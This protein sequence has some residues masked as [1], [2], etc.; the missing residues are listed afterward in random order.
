M[1]Q[2]R[3]RNFC[4]IAHIDHGKSTLTDRLLEVTGTVAHR[5]MV[6]QVMDQMDLEREKGITI[7][8]KAVRMLYRAQDGIEYEM[9]LIDTPG[10]VDF[11]YEVSRA[12][13]ACEGAVLVVDATQG[14]EAQTLAN[15]YLSMPAFD[16]SA[17]QLNEAL[18]LDAGNSEL[19]STLGRCL[20]RQNKW[21][22]ALKAFQ[23][24][25]DTDPHDPE[26]LYNIGDAFLGLSQPEKAVGPLLQ[27]V[28]LRH[29]YSLAHY[30]LSLAFLELRKYPEAETSAR[31][32]LRDDPDMAFQLSNLGMGA[33]G[34]LGIALMNQGQMKEAE[35][36]FRHN[37]G[38]VAST[39]FNLGLTLFRT[40]RFTEALENFRRALELEPENPEFHNLIGQT[41]DE[42][43]QPVEAEQSLRRA[44]EIDGNYALGYYDMGVI[45][46]KREG[47]NQEALVAFEQ[48]LK[49][50]PDIVDAHYA[51]ACL[52]ALSQKEELAL[53]FLKKALQ[54]GFRDIAHIEKDSDWNGFRTN[55]KF[56][57]LLEKYRET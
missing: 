12:L 27:A 35:Q 25:A 46:A 33:T 23:N 11:T 15:L 22:E 26:T 51:I 40:Q 47:R 1:N 29:D 57:R 53:A 6:E 4:I 28:R 5:D 18:K 37:L 13:A 48:A 38:L 21:E 42:L 24:A 19:W 30:D 34:N 9:N 45:L 41:Y 32:A 50:D 3:I 10:H 49:I 14:I 36:C 54:K 7:K 16:E 2:E 20:S 8:A 43:G 17:E 55:P 39:Y 52:H 31:A 44:I 56:I